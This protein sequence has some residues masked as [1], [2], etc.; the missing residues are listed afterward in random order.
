MV[1]NTWRLSTNCLATKPIK[2]KHK[3]KADEKENE[4]DTKAEQKL[5]R[6]RTTQFSPFSEN[7]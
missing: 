2:Q 7:N 3:T 1:E 5:I 4:K 6:K